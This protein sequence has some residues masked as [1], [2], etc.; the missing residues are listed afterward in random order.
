MWFYPDCITAGTYGQVIFTH[1]YSQFSKTQIAIP[2]AQKPENMSSKL[3]SSGMSCDHPRKADRQKAKV[4]PMAYRMDVMLVTPN[5]FVVL[6]KG[7]LWVVSIHG[8]VVDCELKDIR[9]VVQGIGERWF[10]DEE[11]QGV[12]VVAHD[13]CAPVND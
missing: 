7:C 11:I 1:L 2:P 9:C 13:R 8:V 4:K 12:K 3:L 5:L 10:D 6:A